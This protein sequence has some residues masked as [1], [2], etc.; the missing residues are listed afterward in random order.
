MKV[1]IRNDSVV[2]EG[3][4]NAVER[5]SKPLMSRIGKFIERIR[6]GAF[7]RAIKRNNDIHILLN[8][9]WTRDLGSTSEGNLELYEDNIGLHARATITDAGVVEDARRG[10]LV[11]WSFGFKDVPDGVEQRYEDGMPVRVVS[12]LDLHEVSILNRKREPA[13]EGT[14]IMARSDDDV[15]FYGEAF[16]DEIQVRDESGTEQET[17]QEEPQEAVE[18]QMQQGESESEGEPDADKLSIDYSKYEKL[19]SEMKGEEKE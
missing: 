18:E 4:V 8:H 9:D 10:N 15:Q 14:L 16:I 1:N 6:K 2:I 11:G 17:V 13:Y 19:I 3:Y 12:D 5:N 7:S